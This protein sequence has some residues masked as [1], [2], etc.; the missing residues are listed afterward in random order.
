MPSD[1]R[2]SNKPNPAEFRS[3]QATVTGAHTTYADIAWGAAQRG[4]GVALIVALVAAIPV[5]VFFSRKFWRKRRGAVNNEAYEAA[6]AE[7]DSDAKDKGLWARHY[8]ASNGD[9]RKARAAYIRERALII[10][11]ESLS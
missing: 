2:P 5:V 8:A 10:H 3:P 7:L 9:E 11:Q 6:A 1:A 4:L